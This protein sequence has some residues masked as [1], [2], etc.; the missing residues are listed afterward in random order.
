MKVYKIVSYFAQAILLKNTVNLTKE[1]VL[2]RNNFNRLTI[3]FSSTFL[4]GQLKITTKK[5]ARIDN[6]LEKLHYPE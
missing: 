5:L 3:L 2:L 4:Q 6:W 1:L